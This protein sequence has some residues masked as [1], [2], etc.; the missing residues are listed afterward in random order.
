MSAAGALVTWIPGISRDTS[1]TARA[2]N[3]QLIRWRKS[4]FSERQGYER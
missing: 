3:S 1:H 2:L 4:D